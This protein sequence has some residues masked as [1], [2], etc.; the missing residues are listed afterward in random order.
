M[1]ENVETKT[2]IE[3]KAGEYISLKSR[4]KSEVLRRQYVGSVSS[5]GGVSYD[6]SVVP[7]VGD[8]V[9]AEHYNKLNEPLRAVNPDGLLENVISGDRI[10]EIATL[11][12]RTTLLESKALT[13]SSSN[14]GCKASCTGLCSTSCSGTCSG[15]TGCSGTCSGSCSGGCSGCSG[16]GGACSNNCSGSCSG[17]CSGGCSGCTNCTG[18]CNNT[19]MGCT[20]GCSGNCVGDCGGSC[21]GGCWG[22]CGGACA[23]GC[24]TGCGNS[25]S[26]ACWGSGG[27]GVTHFKVK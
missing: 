12:A 14:T 17:G 15:C 2:K 11:E 10:R 7:K 20:G 9:K 3:S 26:G 1:R 21:S 16:C 18:T 27:K 19:C 6:Y 8:F 22:S 4:I 23:N 13:A 5:Y 24:S 25:C